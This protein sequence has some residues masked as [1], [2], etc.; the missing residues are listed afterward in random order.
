MCWPVFVYRLQSGYK[1][2]QWSIRSLWPALP[3]LVFPR[4]RNFTFLVLVLVLLRAYD[5]ALAEQLLVHKSSFLGVEVNHSSANFWQNT[6]RWYQC[7]HPVSTW[8]FWRLSF[9]DSTLC[10]L[11]LAI[12]FQWLTFGDLIQS[13]SFGLQL[14]DPVQRSNAFRKQSVIK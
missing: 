1:I 5:R 12:Q 11:I 8:H 7:Q 6:L 9:G 2:I 4:V 10:G 13:L 14:L 3:S